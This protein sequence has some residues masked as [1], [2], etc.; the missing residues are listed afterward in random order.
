MTALS[1][2]SSPGPRF[3]SRPGE[4]TWEVAE[5]FPCQGSWTEAD[6]LALDTNHMV[7]L[8]DGVVEFLPM[9]TILHQLIVGYLHTLLKAFVASRGAGFVLFAPL[10][11][12]LGPGKFREPDVVY[13]RP[14]RIP[15]LTGQPE[16]ADLV[17]EVVSEGS[18]QRERDIEIKRNEYATAGISEYWIVDPEEQRVTV[19]ALEGTVYRTHGVFGPSGQATSV[20]L[21]GFT[22]DVGAVFAL[23]ESLEK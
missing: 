23:A 2:P 9:P 13:C 22:V 6:Y 21:P 11:V 7:E 12:R 14:E 19:L 18:A 15:K 17:M 20:L 3:V 16:G 4:P 8:S 10:P 1:A 5:L